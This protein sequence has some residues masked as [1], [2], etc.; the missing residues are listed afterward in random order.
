MHRI[1]KAGSSYGAIQCNRVVAGC[2]LNESRYAGGHAAPPHAHEQAYFYTVLRGGHC[3]T[4]GSKTIYPKPYSLV[5]HPAGQKHSH[6]SDPQAGA[7]CFNLEIG[8]EL[9]A[10]L[11]DELAVDD[12][13]CLE[14]PAASLLVRRLY[15]EFRATDAAAP[16]AIEALLLEIMAFAARRR[17]TGAACESRT[18]PWLR[19]ARDLIHARFRENLGVT[20]VAEA[21]GVHPVHLA[22]AFRQRYHS[23]LG[24]YVRR[25][26]VEYAADRI[27][28]GAPSLAELAVEAGFADQSHFSRTFRG[29]MGMSPGEFRRASGAGRMGC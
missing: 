6:R 20:S 19:Q 15:R 21:V 16:L 12:V 22:R 8:T 17:S 3:E 14:D 9:E 27:S 24:D 11:G 4:F 5:F 2:T 28:A 25:L 26:R 10:W 23:T 13:L 1:L 29:I 7:A 18:P